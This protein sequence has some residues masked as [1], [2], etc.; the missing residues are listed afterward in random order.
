MYGW[1]LSIRQI[2]YRFS[3]SVLFN[4]TSHPGKKNGLILCMAYVWKWSIYAEYIL[5]QQM[6]R[7]NGRESCGSEA[8]VLYNVFG[9]SKLWMFG[10]QWRCV[11]DLS[12][13]AGQLDYWKPGFIY[14]WQLLAFN[15]VG[16]ATPYIFCICTSKYSL[17]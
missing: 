13:C 12:V 9:H 1:L 4:H 2:I 10:I 8:T 11:S 6:Q 14:Y 16:K 17:K 3:G 15:D 7:L 5:L